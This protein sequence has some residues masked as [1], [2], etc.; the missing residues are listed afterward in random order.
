M[1][2]LSFAVGLCIVPLATSIYLSAVLRVV[3]LE[4]ILFVLTSAV[5]A[6]LANAYIIN[7][8]DALPAAPLNP[9]S[10][11]PVKNSARL[12]FPFTTVFSLFVPISL[13]VAG[14]PGLLPVL[15][16][17]LFL[18]LTQIAFETIGL[19]FFTFY[20][21]YARLGV[22]IA[23][24]VYRLP[25]II[26]WYNMAVQ[27]ALTEEGKS[28]GPVL[29]AL[30]QAAAVLNLVF[31][32]FSLLCFL[33]LYCLPAVVREPVFPTGDHQQVEKTSNTD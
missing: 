33:L 27:W 5:Y 19:L 13:L 1:Q 16:P 17:H 24:V 14:P 23:F 7:Q 9:R 6:T 28:V 25:V 22:S 4:H 31:W 8:R 21:L 18:M 32:S 2:K 29:P 20:T 30:A 11:T 26:Q 3:P 12:L 15:A 10:L